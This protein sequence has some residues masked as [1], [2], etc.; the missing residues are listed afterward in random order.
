MHDDTIHEIYL[1]LTEATPQLQKVGRAVLRDLDQAVF[2]SAREL[3]EHAGTSEATVGRFAKSLGFGGF[4]EFQ[5]A[6]QRHLR[7]NLLPRERLQRAGPM[8]GSLDG[9]I[10][11]VVESSLANIGETRTRLDVADLQTAADMLIAADSTYVIGMRS[12]S[13]VAHL[14]GHYLGL[15]LPRVH[16][17][18]TGGPSLFENLLSLTPADVALVVSFPRFTKWT[19]DGLRFAQKRGARTIAITD[20]RVSPAAQIADVALVAPGTSVTF[21]NSYVATILLVDALIA[22]IAFLNPEPA[23]A[24]LDELESAF[25]GNDFFYGEHSIMHPLLE[26]DQEESPGGLNT[27]TDGD[28][29]ANLRDLPRTRSRPSRLRTQSRKDGR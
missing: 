14:L 20:S 7:Q 23:L 1:R 19:V 28:S 12:S 21:G 4:P 29:A 3:A 10:D 6:L 11:R 22:A 27:R 17:I 18:T 24:R 16:T 13:S 5:A 9:V 8:P 25:D 26:M 2:M 15:V